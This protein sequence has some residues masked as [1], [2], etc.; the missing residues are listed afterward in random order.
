MLHGNGIICERHL[1]HLSHCNSLLRDLCVYFTVT[2]VNSL[3]SHRNDA[4][5]QL[6]SEVAATAGTAADSDAADVVAAGMGD[7]LKSSW[8]SSSLLLLLSFRGCSVSV[9][10]PTE[11]RPL[12][13][14]AGDCKSHW[15]TSLYTTWFSCRLACSI[16]FLVDGCSTR[17]EDERRHLTFSDSYSA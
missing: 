12:A 5:N 9:C 13:E 14:T 6:S 2:K 4:K 11:C 16:S 17:C 8:S 15:W 1:S 10:A 3:Q 7:I